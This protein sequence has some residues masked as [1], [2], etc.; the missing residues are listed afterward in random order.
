MF[1]KIL[2]CKII[3]N[4]VVWGGDRHKVNIFMEKI[5]TTEKPTLTELEAIKQYLAYPKVLID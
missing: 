4:G 5:I 3:R 2:F 1:Y